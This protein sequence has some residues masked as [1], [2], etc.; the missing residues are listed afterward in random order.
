MSNNI[1]IITFQQIYYHT[2][3]LSHYVSICF[4]DNFTSANNMSVQA[5]RVWK[6][7]R[8][9]ITVCGVLEAARC[10]RNRAY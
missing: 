4:S 3:I 5:E 7:C 10:I 1:I 8:L 9:T 6:S 2:Y